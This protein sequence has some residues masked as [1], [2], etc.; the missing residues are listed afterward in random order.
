MPENQRTAVKA[1]IR[2][3]SAAGQ[4]ELHALDAAARARLLRLYRQTAADLAQEISA[5]ANGNPTLRLEVLQALLA[6]VRT[7]LT[8]LE[9]ARNSLLDDSLLQAAQVGAS[10]GAA[11]AAVAP[12]VA[13]ARAAPA[14][15]V[16]VPH[17][18]VQ[19]VQ[20]FVAQDGLQLSDRLW[21]VDRGARD[22]IAGAIESAVIQ[23]HSA[24]RA[25]QDMLS[26]GAAVPADLAAKAGT[27]TPDALTRTARELLVDPENAYGKLER[28]FRTE[29]NRAHAH[30]YRASVAGV[31]GVIGV[32]FVLSP[33][34]PRADICDLHASANLYG[35][36]P[37]VYPLGKSPWPAHPNTLSHEEVVFD[38]EVSDA[39]QAGRESPID[40]LRAQDAGV[41][42]AVLNSRAKA[43]ALREGLLKPNEINTP[44][45]VLKERYRR[46]GVDVAALARGAA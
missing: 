31:D 13:V 16:Q 9:T 14:A 12:A 1:T 7:R 34:H 44:W 24:S 22:A 32:R 35:L 18:A 6:Q 29:I 5:A 11:G 28:I 27:A 23:G 43:A 4:R 15:L 39:D 20:R 8:A 37:G 25:V 26:R 33:N 17:E 30:A 42:A 46:R 38:D 21:R 3:A 41:Q 10:V 40:W 2:R 45:G 36:G 19:F